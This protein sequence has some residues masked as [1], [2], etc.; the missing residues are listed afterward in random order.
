MAIQWSWHGWRVRSTG[1]GSLRIEADGAAQTLTA[2]QTAA[3]A[4][5]LVSLAQLAEM[6][7]TSGD[8]EAA[9]KVPAAPAPV[10]AKQAAVAPAAA[11]PAVVAPTPGPAATAPAPAIEPR[12]KVKKKRA[13]ATYADP[14]RSRKGSTLRVDGEP[15]KRGPK[16]AAERFAQPS[17]GRSKAPAASK[18]TAP[19]KTTATAKAEATPVFTPPADLPPAVQQIVASL[20]RRARLLEPLVCW[21]GTLG[22]S[23][24]M[25]EI[26]AAAKEGSWSKSDN[27]APAL[28]ASMQRNANLFHRYPDG[29]FT[30]RVMLPEAKVVRRRT[31]QARGTE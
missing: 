20:D 23:A 8:T 28:N 10:A 30:L 4:D 9:A 21:L 12:E 15:V 6:T 18:T 24:T 29:S 16:A 3:F 25:D 11:A 31:S 2:E 13:P 26:V 17:G 27:P 7:E 14:G 22:K 1:N 19:P 5:V